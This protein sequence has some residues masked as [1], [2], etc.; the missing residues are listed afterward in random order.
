MPGDVNE[1][2]LQR[3]RKLGEQLDAAKQ[4][5]ES[6][7]KEVSRA[8]AATDKV[9]A[10]VRLLDTSKAKRTRRAGKKR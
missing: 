7:V 6:T 1:E 10:D 3:L 4:S 8:K 2:V 9:K 5:A